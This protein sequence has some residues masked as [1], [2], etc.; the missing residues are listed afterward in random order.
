MDDQTRTQVG[1]DCHVE[2]ELIDEENNR[3]RLEFDLVSEAAADFASG[4]LGVNSPLGKAIRGKFV[5]SMVEYAMGDIRKV[6]II[7]VLPVQSKTSE[8]AA[9]RRQAILDEAL[10][11]A[12]RTNADMFASS[13]SGK[14]G[15]YNTGDAGDE[16]AKKSK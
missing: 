1:Q 6:R 7:R 8:D 12:E 4:R 3:E 14:W 15:D 5:G 13:Y 2:V 9:A 16:E 10:H 11:K